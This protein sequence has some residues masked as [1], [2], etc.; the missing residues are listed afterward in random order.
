MSEITV[1]VLGAGRGLT[2]AALF[3]AH[4]L[5]TV[6]AVADA[7]DA[8]RDRALAQLPDARG[9]ASYEDMLEPANRPDVV[10]VASSPMDHAT[11]VCAALDAGCA[12]LSEVP[13]AHT[14]E[15]AQ[16]IVDTVARTGGFYMLGEN[17]NWY[18]YILEWKRLIEAGDLGTIV[19]AE[20]EYIH[21]LRDMTWSSPDGARLSA[22]EGMSTPGARAHWR[23]NYHPIRYLTHS[24]GPLLMLMQTRCTHA[25]CVAAPSRASE[26]IGSPDLEVAIF[27][28]QADA[29]I[30]QLCGFSVPREPG[31]QWF[32]VYGT[33]GWVDWQPDR[34]E[35]GRLY[36]DGQEEPEPLPMGWSIAPNLGVLA[37]K[38]G[39]GGIDA[40]LVEAFVEAL[41]TGQAPPIDV[42][43]AMDYTLPGIYAMM[44]AEQGGE[45]LRIPDTRAERIA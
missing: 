16:N 18:G 35:G 24:L 13:A 19:H 29:P 20:G 43:T 30:R 15:D 12:V 2:L 25:S 9:F 5:T 8:L 40:G 4:P 23:A 3:D 26:A 14:L 10:V 36:R 38:G 34:Q 1:G 27:R 32:S 7:Y 22:E 21:D 41:H 11:H 33:K 17:C 37:G 28:T 44:S 31:G 6:T 42:H 45:Q 39:H